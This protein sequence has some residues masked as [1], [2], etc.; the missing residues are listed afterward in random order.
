MFYNIGLSCILLK[1]VKIHNFGVNYPCVSALQYW[2]LAIQTPGTTLFIFLWF[3]LLYLQFPHA[4]NFQIHNFGGKFNGDVGKHPDKPSHS[5]YTIQQSGS[6]N[7]V[8]PGPN[9]TNR[10]FQKIF[11]FLTNFYLF[12]I[13]VAYI[14]WKTEN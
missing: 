14:A 9:P 11:C 5:S 4:H 10:K 12:V 6:K 8:L 2:V 3:R 1:C 7:H 13:E